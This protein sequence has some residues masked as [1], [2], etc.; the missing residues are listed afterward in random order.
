MKRST[1]AVLLSALVFPGA[2]QLYLKKYLPAI[3]LVVAT[4][5]AVWFLMMPLLATA[6]EIAA[7]LVSGEL[8][9][10]T[11]LLDDVLVESQQV[12]A[13]R[14]T[15]LAGLALLGIWLAGVAHAWLTGR[16]QDLRT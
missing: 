12:A 14:S 5:V 1:K 8:Q 2:G 13:S 10:G 9:A 3:A 11:E 15:R 7:R 6:N 4:V 16:Q